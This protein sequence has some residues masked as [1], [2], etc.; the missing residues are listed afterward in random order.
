MLKVFLQYCSTKYVKN[1]DSFRLGHLKKYSAYCNTK[2]Y[3]YLFNIDFSWRF[4]KPG[5]QVCC[6]QVY[7]RPAKICHCRHKSFSRCC[8]CEKGLIVERIYSMI[9]LRVSSSASSSIIICNN[10]LNEFPSSSCPSPD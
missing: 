1:S 2:A 8:R 9:S 4:S 10:T 7:H 3:D 6:R 5:T